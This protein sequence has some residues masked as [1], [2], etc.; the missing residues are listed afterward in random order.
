[1]KQIF[2]LTLAVALA[3]CSLMG[4]QNDQT[5]ETNTENTE[6]VAT[7]STETP[8]GVTRET[9]NNYS[10]DDFYF[11]SGQ[12]GIVLKHS[13]NIEFEQTLSTQPIESAE[14]VEGILLFQEKDGLQAQKSFNLE[15]ILVPGF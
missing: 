14:I 7:E 6:T 5:E 1:M 3:G 8:T 10:A 11:E 13:E 9:K 15:A 2:I 12:D 4:T